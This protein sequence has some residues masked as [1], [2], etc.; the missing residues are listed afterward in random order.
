M[1]DFENIKQTGLDQAK[2]KYLDALGKLFQE[3]SQENFP[4]LLNKWVSKSS[5]LFAHT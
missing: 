2:I 5:P 4:E 3:Q 1:P